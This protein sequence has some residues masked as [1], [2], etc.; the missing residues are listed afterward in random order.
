MKHPP[1]DNGIKPVIPSAPVD[2]WLAPVTRFLHVQSSSGIVLI[3]A[4][5]VALVV[6]NSPWAKGYVALLHLPCQ[7]SVGGW[8][9]TKDLL[10]VVNDG[11]MTIFF[12]VVGLEI[13]RELVGGEL[14]G[15]KKAA[16]P[17]VAAIGGM[18]VPAVSFLAV[19][20][21]GNF[22]PALQRGWAIPMATDIAFVVG[23]LALLGPRI[24]PGLQILLLS[25]AIVDDVG[26]VLVIALV[27]TDAI[28]WALLAVAAGGCVL[29]WLMNLAG[30]RTVAVYVLVGVVVWLAVL[31]SGVHP[32][33][34]GVLLGL[35]TPAAP[36]ISTAKLQ[37]IFDRIAEDARDESLPQALMQETIADASLAAREAISPLHRLESLLHPWVAF[38]IM[39]IF[40]LANA[41]VEVRASEVTQPLAMAVAAGLAIGK[42]VGI[43]L[44]SAAAV[45]L[46]IG[47]LPRGVTW[48]ALIGGGCLGGIGF[49]MS[50]F[51]TALAVPAEHTAA[52]K[53]GTLTGSL[54][55][56]IVGSAV[57]LTL[58]PNDSAAST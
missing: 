9:L 36:W 31:K 3:L 49:T 40:A 55:S 44:F 14:S 7:I 6:A 16:L 19:A 4:T 18:I 48:R 39:P 42:P 32:T 5:A 34:A 33:V 15:W 54:L 53:I 56:V 51:L 10:H 20:R 23:I 58:K 46:G 17:V 21:L 35:M 37:V 41:G 52:G 13:K 27:Y 8:V 29:T 28:R 25:L 43:V 30:V 57:L 50:L 22:D 12:F 45:A 2:R 11:L 47:S 26:A 38:V 1:R 24:A